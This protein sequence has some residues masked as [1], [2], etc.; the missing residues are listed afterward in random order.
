MI[1]ITDDKRTETELSVLKR[2]GGLYIVS[3]PSGAGKTTL[4]RM[5]C[6]TILNIEHS[7]SFTTRS[8]RKSEKDGVDYSFVDR[9]EFMNMVEANEFLE[10]AEVHGNYYGTSLKR[11]EDMQARGLDV[12]MDIDVQ[13]A[14]QLMQRRIDAHF[15]FILPPSLPD[16]TRRLTGRDTDPPDVIEKRLKKAKEEI[17]EYKCYEYVIINDS[18]DEALDAMIAI[19]KA[20]RSS[21]V[22]IDHEWIE[23]NLLKEEI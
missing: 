5:L 10:W 23:N 4:C 17:S 19:V 3:A 15:L 12:I 9:D 7:V 1:S 20:G 22:N 11:I 8:P 6:D 14:R 18:L 13:G 21:I 2:K 16:L